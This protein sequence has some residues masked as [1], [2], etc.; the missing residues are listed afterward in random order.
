MRSNGVIGATFFL[1]SLPSGTSS[2]R[3]NI[4]GLLRY[5]KV[6]HAEAHAKKGEGLVESRKWDEARGEFWKARDDFLALEMKDRASS[7]LSEEALCDF[8]LGEMD[9]AAAA[10]RR[11][12]EIK[13]QIGDQEGEATNLLAFG[14]V[15]LA[16]GKDDEAISS[17]KSALILFRRCD[18][19]DGEV[20]SHRGLARAFRSMR[21]QEEA[22]SEEEAAESARLRLART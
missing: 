21:K 7:M 18:V 22:E 8:A 17:Y 9:R 13:V 2:R 3:D 19:I 20:Q 4:V 10:L 15:L 6:D 11:S 16:Q 14:D 5:V 1:N 12:N